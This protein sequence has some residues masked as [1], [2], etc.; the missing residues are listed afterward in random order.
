M[1]QLSLYDVVS[2]TGAFYMCTVILIMSEYDS[3]PAPFD[4][5]QLYGTIPS[6]RLDMQMLRIDPFKISQPDFNIHGYMPSGPRLLK[7]RNSAMALNPF[8]L[9]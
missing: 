8:S 4:M 7:G 1:N 6:I 5:P 2:S 3:F 9:Y